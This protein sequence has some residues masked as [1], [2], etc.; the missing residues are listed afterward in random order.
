MNGR[1]A[2]IT[3]DV[4]P[5]RAYRAIHG[6]RRDGDGDQDRGKGKNGKKG[7]KSKGAKTKTNTETNTETDLETNLEGEIEGEIETRGKDDV[8][9]GPDARASDPIYTVALPRFWSLIEEIGAP[10]TVFVVGQDATR[11]AA[12]FEPAHRTGSEIANHSFAHDYRLSRKGKE[13]IDEDLERARLQLLPLAGPAGVVGFRAPGYNVSPTLLRCLVSAGYLYDASLLPAPAYFGLRAAA[14]A[15]YAL[16]RQPSASCVG[17][18][19]QFAGP[20]EPYRMTADRPWKPHPRGALVEIPIACEPTTRIPIIGTTWAMFPAPFRR[21]L[22]ARAQARLG[23][24]NFEM[25]A[26]DLL[27][28]SDPG[29]PRDIVARQRDLHIPLSQKIAAFRDLF[30]TLGRVARFRTLRDVAA[31]LMSASSTDAKASKDTRDT[32]PR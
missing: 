26:I 32:P 25:H 18:P 17:H 27:D 31:D 13:E 4:D 3:I 11:Y 29:I 5:L 16:A 14:I 22:L 30:A 2:S 15:A 20:L 19:L 1:S 28:A 24:L 12:A 7:G 6:L 9:E 8:D 10:A 23:H 21:A